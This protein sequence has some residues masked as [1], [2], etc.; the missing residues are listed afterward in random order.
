MPQ[1]HDAVV[2]FTDLAAMAREVWPELEKPFV[3]ALLAAQYI[4]GPAVSTFEAEWAAAC[5]TQHAIGVANGTDALILTLEALGVGAGDEVVL[6]SNTFI[7]TAEAVVRAGA[8]PRFA[9]V[10]ADTMLLTPQTVADVLGPRTKGVI[11]VHLYGQMPDMEALCA[12]ASAAGLF[13]LE[14]AAQ[15]HGAS[16]AGRPAGSW[17]AAGCFSF[18]PG[19]NLGA[20]GDGG[21]VV[22]NDA[23]LAE[24]VR[25]LANHGRAS[26]S[27]HYEHELV[28]T[29][30]RLDSLQALALSAKLARNEDWT[31]RRR[32]LADLYRKQLSDSPVQLQG[33]HP[34]A[35]HVYHLL[36]VRVPQRDTVRAQLAERGIQTGI[37]Y[38]L[39]CHQQPPLQRFATGPLPVVE[40]AAPRLV[41][42]P[43]FP[44]MTDEQVGRVADAVL[45]VVAGLPAESE[46]PRERS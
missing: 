23:A 11:P 27:A 30:S 5:G 26:G 46:G 16:W 32:D 36:V 6:P 8:V 3:E 13:V 31:E 20:F 24:T 33:V 17:G 35:R 1:D 19:K 10:D 38:P 15:A 4:G 42:L 14:D 18:Y 34:A 41:S 2:P 37:H 25:T 22:T 29:N 12:Q 9:D 7:A 40:A 45:E 39:P 43:M 44:H 21:A 28:G